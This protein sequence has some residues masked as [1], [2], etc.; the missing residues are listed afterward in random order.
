MPR[1]G[2]PT[3]AGY[4]RKVIDQAVNRF[5]VHEQ[6]IAVLGE[7]AGGAMAYVVGFRHREIVRAIA[8]IDAPTPGRLAGIENEPA[9][10]LAILTSVTPTS[11]LN[12]RIE[13][14]IKTFR[15]LKFP[16]TELP[17]ESSQRSIDA[18]EQAQIGR[19]VDSLDR[20]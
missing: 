4:L 11:P 6:R 10:R 1:D 15:E 2:S 7:G 18:D 13:A 19:W 16:V 20:L 3:E 12:E 5:A 9:Q 17:R 8:A 14:G